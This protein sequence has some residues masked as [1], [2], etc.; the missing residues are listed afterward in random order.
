MR[1]FFLEIALIKS[2]LSAGETTKNTFA[3]KPCL[4]ASCLLA[5]SYLG[6]CA[7]VAA[8]GNKSVNRCAKRRHR[9]ETG[10]D[11]E[12]PDSPSSPKSVFARGILFLIS[13]RLVLHCRRE[14]CGDRDE[15]RVHGFQKAQLVVLRGQ[16]GNQNPPI[17]HTAG[18]VV[19]QCGPQCG[20]D[21]S[22]WGGLAPWAG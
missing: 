14:H 3:I 16:G 1:A 8:P 22:L 9:G 17:D 2:K 5:S 6:T 4:L 21:R 13:S 12:P 11:K 20:D 19:S 18:G 10:G 7:A 15:V